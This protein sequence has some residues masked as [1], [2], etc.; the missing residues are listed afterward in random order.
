MDL[1]TTQYFGGPPG[2]GH[3]LPARPAALLRRRSGG[4]TAP[5]VVR[6]T[7]STCCCTSAA[8]LLLARLF[9]RRR[10]SAAGG[11][12]ARR[13]SSPSSD[14]RG[15]R[16]EHRRA[17]RDAGGGARRWR[18]CSWRCGS[19]SAER[20][21]GPA[22]S[23]GAARPALRA[24]EP[25][26]GERRRGAGAPLPVLAFRAE[27]PLAA[28]LR[29]QRCARGC[30]PTSASAAVLW[31]VF[32][33]RAPRCSAARSTSRRTGHLRAR[34]P[35]R[36][37]CRR[38][39]A[40]PTHARSSSATSGAWPLPLRL[41]ADESAW[42]IRP[43]R[44][45]TTPLFWAAP[46]CSRCW[47]RR[48]LARR[49]RERSSGRARLS[50][51]RHRVPADVEPALCDGH[52]LRASASP[53]CRRPGYCL[54]AAAWIAG[55][56]ASA[57]GAARASARARPGGG[58]SRRANDR[59]QP[60]LGRATRRSSPTWCESR[61][62][63]AKAHYD[64]AYMSAE[65]GPT[66]DAPSS[67]TTRA[68]EIYPRLLGR[69]GGARAG[70]SGSSATSTRPRSP[71]PR[72][73]GSFRRTRTASSASVS[74]AKTAATRRAPRRRTARAS[75]AIPQ[76]LPLAYRLALLLSAEGRPTAIYAWRRALAIEPRLAAVAPRLRRL[77]RRS[78][79]ERG[80]A[81]A[82][83]R[84]CAVPRV[85]RAL[86]SSALKDRS[87]RAWCDA[88]GR[89]TASPRR[90]RPARSRRRAAR[91]AMRGDGGGRASGAPAR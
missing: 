32:R 10:H 44:G 77:A 1:F 79:P 45:L 56:A 9:L 21:G 73:S 33:L 90:R 47:P 58:R 27:R 89:R 53:T 71:T 28:P 86:A 66:R 57:S 15:G 36:V 91:A 31:G 16:D 69:L 46:R 2:T 38:C 30:L 3:R 60:G 23:P 83:A 49:L 55:R 26:E 82:G 17:G 64:F 80:G 29:A 39:R 22:L 13:C 41:S 19:A 84:R 70:W 88:L 34:E 76:S 8:T 4:S 14:P 54:I 65:N 51:P 25:D 52:D 61:P 12:R 37:R 48:P 11:P 43:A 59:A 35:A 18:R 78:G 50:L 67:T 72:R 7:P 5:T 87:S 42:S 40:P 74:R 63:S 85:T 24:R 20:G 6:T 75:G 81:G 68:T 62:R